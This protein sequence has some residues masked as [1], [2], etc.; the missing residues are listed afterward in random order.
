MIDSAFRQKASSPVRARAAFRVATSALLL[1]ASPA[2]WADS[3]KGAATY[4]AKSGPVTVTVKHAYLIKGPDDM[5]GKMGR[6]L[7]FA[8]SDM[9][10]AIKKCE[11]MS[12]VSGKLESGLTADLDRM[13][14][15][16]F[17]MVTN[18]QRIQ[19]SG[20]ADLESLTLT[21]DSP[22]KMAGKWN[23]DGSAAGMPKIDVDFD[24]T[25]LKEFAKAR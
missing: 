25:L 24:V 20:T 14:R 19:V 7:V 4:A 10:D 11:T 13:P 8:A 22:Q 3:A 23:Y 21:T 18:G 16:A 6:Q 5:S 9:A 2:L 1:A 17:W 15:V 12:C